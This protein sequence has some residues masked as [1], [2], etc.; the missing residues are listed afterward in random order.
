LE[1]RDLP[2]REQCCGFGGTF[3]VKNADVSAAMLEAKEVCVLKTGA[4]VVTALDNSCLMQIY[5]GL[6]RAGS[7]VRTMHIAE[8]LAST[9]KW[10][11]SV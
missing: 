1:L 6:H 4:E 3:A 2:E 8:I 9:E 7:T 5:G 10:E 11:G